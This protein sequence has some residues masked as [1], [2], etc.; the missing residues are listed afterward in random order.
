VGLGLFAYPYIKYYR[1][2][3]LLIF[4]CRSGH[5]GKNAGEIYY[6]V[7]ELHFLSKSAML[8]YSN[9]CMPSKYRTAIV[10]L[11]LNEVRV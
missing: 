2:T 3:N 10:D 5:R 4:S 7:H 6:A 11:L 9:I 1:C 8:H